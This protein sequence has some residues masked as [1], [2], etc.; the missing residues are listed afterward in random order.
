MTVVGEALVRVRPDTSTFALETRSGVNAALTG[1][2]GGGAA[3]AA[4][5]FGGLGAA[6]GLVTLGAREAIGGTADLEQELNVLRATAQATDEQM[7]AIAGTA[8]D[9][10][11]DLTL[12]AVSASDAASSMLELV[13]GGLD[14]TETI[15]GARGVLQLGTAANL[16]FAD[17]AAIVARALTTF[18]RPGED[19]TI[20]ADLLVGAANAATGEVTDMAE[21]LEAGGA[22]ASSFGL[23]LEDTVTAV[24]L[25]ARN[26]ILGAEAG[27]GL[28]RVLLSLIGPTRQQAELMDALGVATQDAAG[29]L[30]PLPD[31]FQDLDDAMQ[32]L[33]EVQ[34]GAVL[35]EL[36][37]AFGIQAASVFIR[38]GADAT[39]ELQAELTRGGQA[40]EFAEARTEGLKGQ[41]SGLAS[42]LETLGVNIGQFVIPPL[43]IMAETASDGVGALNDLFTAAEQFSDLE[44]TFPDITLPDLPFLDVPGSDRVQSDLR[45]TERESIRVGEA[46]GDAFS[47]AAEQTAQQFAPVLLFLRDAGGAAED[48]GD[49]LRTTAAETE[50]IEFAASFD[51]SAVSALTAAR[52]FH[53]VGDAVEE[54]L[55]LKNRGR[56]AGKDLGDGLAEGVISAEQEAVNAARQTLNRVL[57]EGREAVVE[58]IRQGDEAV[59]LSAVD[60]KQ[61]LISIGRDLAGS[62]LQ[63]LEEGPLARRIDALRLQL[64]RQQSRSERRDLNER[65][66]DAERALRVARDQVQVAGDLT[67]AQRAAQ[68]RFLEPFLR[69]V[70]D[71]KDAL[72]DFNT[73]SVIG[74]LEAQAEEQRRVV[75]QGIADLVVQFN[76][77]AITLTALNTRVAG[78]LRRNGIAPYGAAGR[79]LGVAFRTEFAAELEALQRQAAEIIGGLRVPDIGVEPRIVSP[80]AERGRQD[81][82]IAATREDAAERTRLAQDALRR[83][84]NDLRRSTEDLD[85]TNRELMAAVIANT[86]ALRGQPTRPSVAE[87]ARNDL[88]AGPVPQ[89]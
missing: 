3:G 47:K 17:S 21:A 83:A 67:P 75:Q 18:R 49:A 4:L 46:I 8:K 5:R 69:D 86:R 37:G 22:A 73:E 52:E 33:T 72:R 12:P 62:A 77:G 29:D 31:I 68:Q 78:L 6:I 70:Q 63:A 58:A 20:V 64:G 66:R 25:L 32:G 53:S 87:R 61:N 55:D 74:T 9:L 88:P 71:A 57:R 82:R 48:L 11:A 38:E 26:G 51:F 28:R 19:A 80:R 10:G 1:L 30:R 40:A 36:F 85:G 60:A 89:R 50:A 39:R 56:K 65:L 59:R 23:S 43:T 13:K 2:G 15:D 84:Q 42:Q 34:R 81:E 27:T 35:T 14:V 41:A 44:F 24:T 45:D 79:R 7:A 54:A 16:A 76:R